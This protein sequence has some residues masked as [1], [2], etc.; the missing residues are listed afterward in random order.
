MPAG[1]ELVKDNETNQNF[2][3]TVSEDGKIATTKI[4]ENISIPAFDKANNNLT[5]TYVD[6]VCKVTDQATSGSILTNIA[7]IKEDNIEDRDSTPNSLSTSID[8][9]DKSTY[10]G[11]SGNTD[12]TNSNYYYKGYED[13]DDFERVIVAG[14]AFDLSLQKFIK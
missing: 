3:W 5:N 4:T 2:G 8:S 13:D 7:E 14:K 9:I 6:I 10:I 11:Q 1:L 12:L